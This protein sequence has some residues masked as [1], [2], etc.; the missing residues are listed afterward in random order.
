MADRVSLAVE[1]QAALGSNV[2]VGGYQATALNGKPMDALQPRNPTFKSC[3]PGGPAL[4][5]A[6]ALVDKVPICSQDVGKKIAD[7]LDARLRELSHRLLHQPSA[8]AG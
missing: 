3:Y 5:D 2:F 4:D 8:G 6:A 1:L 7:E